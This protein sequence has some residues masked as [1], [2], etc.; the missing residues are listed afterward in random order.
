M[1]RPRASA[2]VGPLRRRLRIAA[3][4][5]ILLSWPA[6]AAPQDMASAPAAHGGTIGSHNADEGGAL[7]YVTL[8]QT[9]T[10]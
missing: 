6:Q 7:F 9:K 2:G 10:A 5:L 4:L 1:R 3:S 8:P